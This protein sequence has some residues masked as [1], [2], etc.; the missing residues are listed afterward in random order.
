MEEKRDADAIE[1]DLLELLGVLLGQAWLILG[2]GLMAALL[3]FA[4]SR[5]VVTPTY[6]STTKIYILNKD[7]NTTVTYTD[8]QLGSQ[9][10]K[11]YAELIGSRYVL[12]EVIQSLGL[13][14]EY[15]GLQKKVSVSTPEG[16]RVIYITVEDND[17]VMAMNIANSVREAASRH[18][19]N[20]MDIDAVN[21]VETANMPMQK[22]AP[23]CMRWTFIGGL[24]GCFFV[25]A[26]VLVR[27]LMDDTVKSSE[28][29]EKYLGLTTLALIPVQ[30]DGT[31]KGKRKKKKRNG[32]E[33]ME[34]RSHS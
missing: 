18:I 7:E 30:E 17:P 21:V 1:I 23:S 2:T 10:T 26:V 27:F 19:E 16:T 31:E 15:K 8:V 6:E 3:A 11:D 34:R 13:D 9:L 29:V 14:M 24:L 32:R 4:V 20:V 28:D 22:S 12:E 25:C 33:R 5:F